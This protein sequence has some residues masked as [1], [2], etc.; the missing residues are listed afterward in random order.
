MTR[1]GVI[2]FN[3]LKQEA[4]EAAC[5]VCLDAMREK[6]V[7]SFHPAAYFV[8]WCYKGVPKDVDNIVACLKGYLD[9]CCDAM[10]ID[11]RT[12]ELAGVS[13]IHTKVPGV[14]KTVTIVFI[15]EWQAPFMMRFKE[16]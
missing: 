2:M 1:G 9:G 8:A 10:G 13:R 14:C 16:I 12:L 4:R 7:L 11:D 6:G 15:E 3:R 5:K